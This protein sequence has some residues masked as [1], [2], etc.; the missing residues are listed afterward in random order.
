MF[1]Y[2]EQLG[3]VDPYAANVSLLLKGDGTNNST[4]IFDS[5]ANN[6]SITRNGDTKISTAQSKFGGSSIYFDG[7]SD[8]LTTQDNAML[9]FGTGDFTVEGWIYIN[10]LNSTGASGIFQISP[11]GINASAT[12]SVA[13]HLFGNNTWSIYTKNTYYLSSTNKWSLNT[14]HHF[15]YV[16]NS[17]N[18]KLYVDG[19]AII[20]TDDNTNYT[21]QQLGIGAVYDKDTYEFYGYIDD[22]RITKGVARYTATFTP[23]GAL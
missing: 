20:A 22:F 16:R 19:I 11:F 23:P 8:Y 12:N 14:W 21:G 4:N 10:S 13:L 9:Q 3:P 7:A 5:S 2:S 6:L 17:G 18:T 15:A 1:F